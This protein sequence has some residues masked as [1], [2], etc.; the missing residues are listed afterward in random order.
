[1]RR[2]TSG[3]A[4]LQRRMQSLIC[5][6]SRTSVR[7]ES[8][9]LT[10]SE[11][12]LARDKKATWTY[13]ECNGLYSPTRRCRTL[14]SRKRTTLAHRGGNLHHRARGRGAAVSRAKDSCGGMRGPSRRLRLLR[15]CRWS[16]LSTVGTPATLRYS[17]PQS[18]G[19]RRAARHYEQRRVAHAVGG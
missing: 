8:A 5:H 18:H 6:P 1:M 19:N 9:F 17:L 15:C 11:N 13:F 12:F 3:R 2:P 7:G 16:H 14:L 4:V 10:F